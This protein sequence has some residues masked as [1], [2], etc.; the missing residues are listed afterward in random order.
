M[1]I[2]WFCIPAGVLIL[3]S[4]IGLAAANRAHWFIPGAVASAQTEG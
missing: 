2:A 3:I 4:L 1:K